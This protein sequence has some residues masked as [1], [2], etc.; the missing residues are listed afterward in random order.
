MK[1]HGLTPRARVLGMA[2][3]GV[4]PRIMGIGPVPATQKL[5]ARLGLKIGDFDVIELNEA[6]AA[7]ALAVLRQLGLPDDADH[8]NPNGGAIALGHPLGMSGARLALTATHQLE[9][10]GGK[11]GAGDHVHRRRPG[12]FARARA[13]AVAVTSRRPAIDSSD[14]SDLSGTGQTPRCAHPEHLHPP[15]SRLS[16]TAKRSPDAAA[17]H[18]AAH[19]VRGDRPGLRPRERAAPTTPTSRGQHAGEPLGERIIV[20]GRVLDEDARPVPNTLVEIWQANAAGRYIHTR[21]PAPC[22][23]RSQ[24]H[25]R[26]PRRHR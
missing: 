21:R 12:P 6:F 2:S 20:H 22:A 1:A 14:D 17:R 25:R 10:T 5:M 9:K 3:A 16:L 26:R 15:I 8:V 18:P 24:F 23:A 4:P 19:A 11:R 7:Q 13:G